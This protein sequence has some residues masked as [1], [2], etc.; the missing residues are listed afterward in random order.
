[1]IHVIDSENEPI[2]VVAD[3]DVCISAGQCV[4]E[5]VRVFAQDPDDGTVIVLNEHPDPADR[6]AAMSAAEACPSGAIRLRSETAG[7]AG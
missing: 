7:D 3:R 6:A 2:T 1:M 5:A 4:A